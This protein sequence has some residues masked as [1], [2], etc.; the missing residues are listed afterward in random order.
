[1]TEKNVDAIDEN[2]ANSIDEIK[3]K[4]AEKEL[5][6]KQSKKSKIQEEKI[7]KNED[8]KVVDF[9]GFKVEKSVLSNR[10]RQELKNTDD[11][12]NIKHKDDLLKWATRTAVTQLVVLNLIIIA[13]LSFVAFKLNSSSDEKIWTI[14]LDKSFFFL[15]FYVGATFVELLGLVG[16]IVKFVFSKKIGDDEE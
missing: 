10:T 2:E 11:E 6:G 1:M 15:E 14:F 3:K 12:M 5:S 13:I 7:D 8:D 9:K 4:I 16:I